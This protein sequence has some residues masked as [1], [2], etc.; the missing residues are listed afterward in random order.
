MEWLHSKDDDDAAAAAAAQVQQQSDSTPA[1]PILPSTLHMGGDGGIHNHDHSVSASVRAGQAVVAKKLLGMRLPEAQESSIS[2]A[3]VAAQTAEPGV[4]TPSRRG[5]GEEMGL[6][7][8][9]EM[10]LGLV[11]QRTRS[12]EIEDPGGGEGDNPFGDDDE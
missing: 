7:A 5:A 10:G 3:E 2:V 9:K 1:T 6:V 8:G 12:S 4:M 11:R